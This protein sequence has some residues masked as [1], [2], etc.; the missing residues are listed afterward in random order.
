MQA[1]TCTFLQCIYIQNIYIISPPAAMENPTITACLM[2]WKYER[3]RKQQ[4]FNISSMISSTEDS[5]LFI[6]ILHR[7]TF[8]Y[9]KIMSLH[10]YKC[11]QCSLEYKQHTFSFSVYHTI[12]SETLVHIQC[13]KVTSGWC[14]LIPQ[15]QN[16][17]ISAYESRFMYSH[18]SN[19]LLDC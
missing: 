11:T 10:K 16:T 5:K 6:Q 14:F 7:L 18:K 9:A 1:S 19:A 2:P 8:S 4:Q 15:L 12:Q 13:K 17:C 3:I